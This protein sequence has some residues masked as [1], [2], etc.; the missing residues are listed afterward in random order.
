VVRSPR[1]GDVSVESWIA[2][3]ITDVPDGEE[4]RRQLVERVHDVLIDV[5]A[6][7]EDRDRMTRVLREVAADTGRGMRHGDEVGPQLSW[8]ADTNLSVL[9]Y[10]WRTAL[11]TPHGP[12]MRAELGTGLG[13][14]RPDD[15]TV[16]TSPIRRTG[17]QP[18][19]SM[20]S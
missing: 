17:T 5:R 3:E 4:G 15:L 13:I 2:V 6:V 16:D 9:S 10:R 12:G 7:A 14:L 19:T 8:F 1:P 18:T 11:D 20:D